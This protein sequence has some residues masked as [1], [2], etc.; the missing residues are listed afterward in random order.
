MKSICLVFLFS[1]TFAS[2]ALA[3]DEDAWQRGISPS[4]MPI[5][6]SARAS[7]QFRCDNGKT[8]LRFAALSDDYCDC[9]DGTD[10]P[11]TS[12]CAHASQATPTFYCA[13]IG[14]ES[15]MLF[16]SLVDD[17][18]CD[19][20]D[21]SDESQVSS[22]KNTCFQEGIERRR[23]L[24]EQ[25]ELHRAGAQL[26]HAWQ[27]RAKI[28]IAERRE[29]VEEMRARL[30]A[31]KR[32]IELIEADVAALEEVEPVEFADVDD[33]A[34]SADDDDDAVAQ[35]IYDRIDDDSDEEARP[36]RVPKFVAEHQRPRRGGDEEQGG[37]S[38]SEEL[39]VLEN[40][41]AALRSDADEL[42]KQVADADA[43][44]ALDLGDANAYFA[45]HGQEYLLEN[46]GYKYRIEPF[47]KATQDSTSIGTFARWTDDGRMLFD[48]G[49]R[50][51][52]GPNR[53]C[54]IEFRC[55]LENQLV[56]A[57]ETSKCV[58]AL[59]METFAACSLDLATDIQAQLDNELLQAVR[60]STDD[61]NL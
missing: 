53:S 46:K 61:I 57:E 52:N 7:N 32:N 50:C 54:S 8:V 19:C 58:Y 2:L 13:N 11:G 48:N 37:D 26:K 24:Q 49:Q 38:D 43:F 36:A 51:W 20:C 5:F 18:F 41:L 21:G 17:G 56:A 22:C 55:A 15:R 9:A 47:V 12:A 60:A 4:L 14:H 27:E 28:A 40:E 59:T 1:L 45:L 31:L 39:E 25:V 16:P 10:E 23:A 3:S 30:D 34:E 44:L 6:E 42:E 33:A 35:D 29:A